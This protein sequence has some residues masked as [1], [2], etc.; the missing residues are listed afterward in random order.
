MAAQVVKEVVPF[1]VHIC[2][3]S[4]LTLQ[5]FVVTLGYGVGVLNYAVVSQI[6]HHSLAVE[7]ISVLPMPSRSDGHLS[8]SL[9]NFH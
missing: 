2:A 9:W 3:P 1:A 6:G 8:D 5:D 7:A 4:K